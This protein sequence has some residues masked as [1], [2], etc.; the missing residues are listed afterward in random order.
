MSLYLPWQSAG[1]CS[2]SEYFGNQG[3]TVCGL[4]N[5]FSG[6]RTLD[7]LSA[8]V[9]RTAALFAL[10]LVAVAAAAWARPGLMRRLPLGRCAL[11]AAYFG[12]A[13][14]VQMRSETHQQGL[15][16]SFHFAYGAYVGL[17]AAIVILIAAGAERR[18]ELAR[19]G[20]ASSIVL[21]LLVAGLLAAFLLPWVRG[22]SRFGDETV[23]TFTFLG[24]TS[25]VA[26]VAAVFAVCLPAPW[27]RP[28]ATL[29]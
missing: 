25:A 3:G 24:I 12:I 10:V 29:L 22:E 26:D 13:V 21:L 19:H 8:E 18:R 11:L 16:G 2:E 15:G 1:S 6:G 28:G 4:L 5:S 7:G 27:S 14:G 17:A 23:V 20:S 9:G